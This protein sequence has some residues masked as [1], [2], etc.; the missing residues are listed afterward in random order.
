MAEQGQFSGRNLPD[1]L[2]VLEKGVYITIRP[3]DGL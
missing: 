2:N 1:V 3:V